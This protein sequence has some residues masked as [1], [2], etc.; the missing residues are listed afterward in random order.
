MVLIALGLVDKDER[1]RDYITTL[2]R[3]NKLGSHKWQ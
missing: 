3:G 1:K 2:D